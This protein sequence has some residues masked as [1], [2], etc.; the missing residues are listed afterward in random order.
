MLFLRK[1]LFFSIILSLL[2]GG[3]LLSTTANH[4]KTVASENAQEED[5]KLFPF[6]EMINGEKRFGYR[7]I[8]GKV[9]IKP[10]FYSARDFEGGYAEVQIAAEKKSNEYKHFHQ[11]DAFTG[12]TLAIIDRT[13]KI[14]IKG[15][16]TEIFN[17]HSD[18]VLAKSVLPQNAKPGLHKFSEISLEVINIKTGKVFL[19][20]PKSSSFGCFQDGIA[21]VGV[22]KVTAVDSNTRS[23]KF[24]YI[25]KD[26]KFK[27]QPTFDNAEKFSGGLALVTK[28]KREFFINA[29]GKEIIVNKVELMANQKFSEGLTVAD[30]G[31]STP[32]EIIDISGK[33]VFSLP[34]N[35]EHPTDWND[36]GFSN[37]LLRVK[38]K[39]T[40]MY[41]YVNKKGEL[42]IATQFK[43]AKPFRKGFAEVIT[44]MN[45]EA[46]IDNKGKIL[47]VKSQ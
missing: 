39:K 29:Q 23:A 11:Y 22:G 42:V 9:L 1:K 6:Q 30:K 41:G 46:Y 45:Q 3:I 12:G 26:G 7:T 16:D 27:I 31:D 5:G 36:V 40:S 37:S 25:G 24:G 13:G 2:L 35:L 10:Q 34:I 43:Y 15:K 33:I 20:P 8:Y 28:E 4:Q 47:W 44:A 21:L 14:V 32:L 19:M 38:N 17:C 18:G